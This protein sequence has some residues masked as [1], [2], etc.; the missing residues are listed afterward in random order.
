MSEPL[1]FSSSV[2]MGDYIFVSGKIGKDPASGGIAKGDIK[3]QTLQTLDNLAAELR[4]Y[5]LGM[6]AAVKTT[7]F[8]TDMRHF[9]DMNSVYRTRFGAKPPA[10]SCVGVSALPNKD[11]LVEIELIAC[12]AS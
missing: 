7:V 1:P 12:S 3:A 10:R 5:G 6:E 4:Q 2:K 11:A 8:L 9:E